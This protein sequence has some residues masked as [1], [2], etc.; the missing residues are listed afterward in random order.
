MKILIAIASLS[1]LLATGFA[2]SADAGSYNSQRAR[3]DREYKSLST[4]TQRAYA[5]VKSNTSTYRSN[6][7][8]RR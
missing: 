2:S 6:S 5:P 4:A 8:Y 7:G 3:Q 1:I